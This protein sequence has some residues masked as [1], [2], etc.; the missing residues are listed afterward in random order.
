M[1][2][3]TTPGNVID[4]VEL[5]R[6]LGHFATGVTVVSYAAD[7]S[8]EFRGTTVNSFT[9]VSL[10]PPLVLVSLGRRSRAAAAL[11]PGRAFAVNVLHPG[12][13]D[14][15]VR[16]AGRAPA[17]RPEPA[18]PVDWEV[19]AGLPHLA[20]CG[21]YFRCAATD[22]HDAG[23]HVLVVALVEAFQAHGHPPLIFHRGAFK[24]LASNE[25]HRT[26]QDIEKE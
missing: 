7:G 26:D 10:E 5:R 19:R 14:L 18:A 1:G 3:A 4:T 15:A 9:S 11:R 16:F 24:H 12:Q 6:A 21:A 17:G 25:Q 22:V 8:G 23:D 2:T 13:R 20:D